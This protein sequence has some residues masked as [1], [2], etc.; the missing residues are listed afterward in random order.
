MPPKEEFIPIPDEQRLTEA[1]AWKDIRRVGEVWDDP[2]WWQKESN[3]DLVFALAREAG[4]EDV[5]P[6]HEQNANAFFDRLQR[7][8]YLRRLETAPIPWS[9]EQVARDLWQNFFDANNYTLDGAVVT[10]ESTDDPLKLRIKIESQAEFDPRRLLHYGATTKTGDER[11]VGRFGVGA[12]DAAFVLLRDYGVDKVTFG[13]G[14]WALDFYLDWIPEGEYERPVRGLYVKALPQPRERKGSFVELEVGQEMGLTIEHAKDFFYHSKNPELQEPSLENDRVWLKVHWGKPGKV[15]LNGQFVPYSKKGEWWEPNLDDLTIYTKVE[16]KTATGTTLQLSQDRDVITRGDLTDV[17]IPFVVESLDQGQ[18]KQLL[19]LLKSAWQRKNE[20]GHR[21]AVDLLREDILLLA[22]G[23]YKLSE[24]FDISNLVAATG[25]TQIESLLE[26]L[27][28]K[29][30]HWFFTEVGV[31]SAR[32][33]YKDLVAVQELEP[34][35]EEQKRI[36][37]LRQFTQRMLEAT[38]S[39]YERLVRALGVTLD[40]SEKGVLAKPLDAKPIK[41]FTGKNRLEGKHLGDF[42]WVNRAIIQGDFNLAKE[43]YLHELCHQYGEDGAPTFSYALSDILKRNDDYR[44]QFP[45]EYEKFR[46]EWE[47]I[48]IAEPEDLEVR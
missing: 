5:K 3:I 18:R 10:K 38:E 1:E 45:E 31:K 34:S 4:Y 43:V 9:K 42:E 26:D 11:A 21:G 19:G 44:D 48:N 36:E 32:K 33:F 14:Q 17:I 27:G 29:V 39:D 22:G 30:C 47:A 37:I 7:G 23:G 35:P 24:Q 41:L 8:L 15:F 6:G 28:F 25:D 20:W 16:A 12:K 46:Q 2:D 40:Y 13:T